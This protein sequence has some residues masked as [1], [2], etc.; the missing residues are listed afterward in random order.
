MQRIKEE[1]R[2]SP[3]VTVPRDQWERMKRESEA[4]QAIFKVRST[5]HGGGFRRTLDELNNQIG[6][7]FKK[8]F[9]PSNAVE[10]Q[11]TQ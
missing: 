7:L 5:E 11:P 4:L 10:P 1:S 2:P 9:T 6:R 3:T 8:E